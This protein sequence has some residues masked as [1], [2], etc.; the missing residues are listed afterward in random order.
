MMKGA[1]AMLVTAKAQIA[2]TIHGREATSRQP[3]ASSAKKC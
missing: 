3:A 1:A 2:A